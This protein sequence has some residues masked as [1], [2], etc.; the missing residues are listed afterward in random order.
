MRGSLTFSFATSE[1]M[2]EKTLTEKIL[3]ALEK[4]LE[5]RIKELKGD[6]EHYSEQVNAVKQALEELNQLGTR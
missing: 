6:L 1:N 3:K 4:E 2:F 5:L